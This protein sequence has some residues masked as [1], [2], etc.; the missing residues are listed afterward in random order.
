MKT[1]LNFVCAHPKNFGAL[2]IG[3]RHYAAN[4]PNAQEITPAELRMQ[5]KN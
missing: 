4:T 5:D 2:P 1:E 3:E